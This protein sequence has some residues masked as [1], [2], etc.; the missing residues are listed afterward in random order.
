MTPAAPRMVLDVSFETRSHHQSRVLR[1]TQYS[2]KLADEFCC[3]AHCTGRFISD[4]APSS[5]SFFVEG[6]VFGKSEGD[7]SC[8]AHSTG[9]CVVFFQSYSNEGFAYYKY[10]QA[11]YYIFRKIQSIYYTLF[12][13]IDFIFD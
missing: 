12:K 8:P 6:A 9:R 5:E 3:S 2:V 4:K 7:S 11:S 1:Q 10:T 13:F